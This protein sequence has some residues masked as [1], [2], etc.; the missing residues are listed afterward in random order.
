SASPPIIDLIR[1]GILS[2]DFSLVNNPFQEISYSGDVNAQ[3]EIVKRTA[4]EKILTIDYNHVIPVTGVK[5][6]GILSFISMAG[7][8][9]TMNDEI[10]LF[11]AKL[12]ELYKCRDKSR[13]H[14]LT[15]HLLHYEKIYCAICQTWISTK[16][17][18]AKPGYLIKHLIDNAHIKKMVD[19][20]LVYQLEPLAFWMYALRIAQ[21]EGLWPQ[22]STKI[23]ATE[24]LPVSH[25]LVVSQ[26]IDPR[27]PLSVLYH[28]T[29]VPN[30][31]DPQWRAVEQEGPSILAGC[32]LRG[33]RSRYPERGS[34]DALRITVTGDTAQSLWPTVI[35]QYPRLMYCALFGDTTQYLRKSTYFFNDLAQAKNRFPSN[36]T[37]S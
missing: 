18:S 4:A 32:P 37:N 10:L 3:K 31:F 8:Q 26:S 11:S 15:K 9:E 22:E 29:H 33:G 28:H 6:L 7:G 21:K 2:R 34:E 20:K 5:P 17:K 14:N 36:F 1:Y 25:S 19:R 27:S 13:F 12:Q 23:Q 35:L 16:W 24:V 30:P